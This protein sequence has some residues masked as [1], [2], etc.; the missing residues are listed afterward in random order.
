MELKKTEEVS[1]CQKAAGTLIFEIHAQDKEGKWIDI[2]RCMNDDVSHNL[3]LLSR[4]TEQ[5]GKALFDDACTVLNRQLVLTPV[6]KTDS[7]GEKRY[8]PLES[9]LSH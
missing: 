5:E 9:V 2:G 7:N 1:D 4:Y 8:M 6:I 3:M